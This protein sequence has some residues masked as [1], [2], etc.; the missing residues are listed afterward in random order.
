MTITTRTADERSGFRLQ[1]EGFTPAHYAAMALASVTG[2]VH[3]YL[4]ATQGYL[5]FLLAGAG[6][7]GAIGLLFLTTK[8]GLIY[9][10]GIPYTLAQVAGWYFAGMPDFALGV[11]DKVAQLGLIV[12]LGYLFL[13]TRKSSRLDDATAA[14]PA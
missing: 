7:F 8:R 2:I 13:Q 3:L 12:L 1:F 14:P 5:P 6:F 10:A 9:L 11:A 4:Y